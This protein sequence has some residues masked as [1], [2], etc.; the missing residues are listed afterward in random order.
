M[1]ETHEV[2]RR[3]VNGKKIVVKVEQDA[4]AIKILG[5]GNYHQPNGGEVILLDLYQPTPVVHVYALINEQ[6]P[7]Y[8]IPLGGAETSKHVEE[9]D[10]Y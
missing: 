2:I 1:P 6:D 4:I 9:D 7:S 5:Y 8:R 10:E 3:N